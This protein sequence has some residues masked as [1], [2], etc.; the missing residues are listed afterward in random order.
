MEV[1]TSRPFTLGL[2]AVSIILTTAITIRALTTFRPT[3]ASLAL[4]IGAWAVIHGWWLL[5]NLPAKT[6][7]Q[8]GA[9][10]SQ[11]VNQ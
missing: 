8:S 4:V 7:M 11:F 2:I 3:F 10:L 6:R 5:R 9:F 1:L